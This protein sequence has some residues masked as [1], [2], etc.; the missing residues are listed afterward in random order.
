[1]RC[2][3]KTGRGTASYYELVNDRL[4]VVAKQPAWAA[5]NSLVSDPQG[6]AYRKGEYLKPKALLSLY[7]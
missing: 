2:L 3:R 6:E 4:Q 7:A 5:F 1:M